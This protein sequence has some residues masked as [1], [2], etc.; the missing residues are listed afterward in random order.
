MSKEET[1]NLEIYNIIYESTFLYL[2]CPE[3]K[4][5]PLLTFNLDNSEQINLKCDKCNNSSNMKL[6]N[7]LKGLSSEISSIAK[8]CENHSNFLDKYCYECHIQFCSKCEESKIHDNHSIRRIIK[9]FNSDKIKNVKVLIEA[10]KK[11]FRNYI[12]SFMNE[13]ISKFPKNRHYFINNNLLK[14]YIEEMKAFFHFCDCV[15]LN[16]NIVYSDYHQQANLDNLINILNKKATL[17]NLKEPKLERLFKYCN[18]NFIYNKKFVE[19]NLT[20]LYSINDFKD[21]IIKSLLIDDELIIIFFKDCL[22]LYNFIKKTCISKLE[23]NLSADKIKLNKINEN[24]I[25]LFLSYESNYILKIYSISSKEII[26][27]KSFDFDIKNIKN[28]NN[29]YFGI[30][31]AHSLEVYA[32]EENSK[33]FKIQMIANIGIPNLIDFIHLS[34]ENYIIALTDEN[35][36][37][38]GKNYNIIENIKHKEEFKTICE[39]KDRH[40]ILGGRIIGLLNIDD[41]SYSVLFN[42]NIPKSE[43]SYL[44]GVD[45]YI[46]YSLFNLNHFNKLICKQKIKK[47][48]LSHYDDDSDQVVTENNLCIFDFNP[49]NDKMKKNHIYKNW[50]PENIYINGNN[51]LIIVKNDCINVYDLMI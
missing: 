47:I 16:Y 23:I 1:T 32:P 24:N 37:I 5:I 51:E 43:R 38:Y 46:D 22:K 3:C 21:T 29:N 11:Y 10:R 9:K 36:I 33:S 4:N 35:I 30:I 2:N 31:K 48:Y 42:D 50:N 17:K 7:Y 39:T 28:I 14:P 45:T 34:K 26:Y 20:L 27:E 44:T 41:R 6:K 12:Q 18:N 49:E 19:D 25:G 40:I 8:K 13:Y 15:L